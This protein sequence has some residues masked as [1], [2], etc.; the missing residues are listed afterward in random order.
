MTDRDTFAAAALT[1]LLAGPGGKTA[2]QWAL[3]AY[4]LADAMLRERERNGA[5]S[6]CE[7]PTLTAEEREAIQKALKW[8]LN[9][10]DTGVTADSLR[11]I[12]E[13]LT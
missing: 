10:R 9:L 3:H 4:S 7:T 2:E 1:G 11:S 8:A 12:L 13:R 6:G 5:V